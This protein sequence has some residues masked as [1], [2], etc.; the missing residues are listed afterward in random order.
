MR[1]TWSGMISF[2]L[3]NIPVKVYTAAREEKISFHQMH[4][5]DS[6]RVRYDKVCKACGSSLSTEDIVKGYEYRKGQYVIITDEDLDKIDLPTTR[7]I[8]VLN[9]VDAAEIDA[10]QFDKG[11]YI[12]PDENGERA[13]SLLRQALTTTGKIG[14]GKVAFRNHEQ[15]AAIRVADNALVLET[16]HFCDEMVGSGGMGCRHAGG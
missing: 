13:Y 12:A 7:S 1:A 4:K 15:L 3:V 5:E 11:F 6:G 8:S 16:L 14:I 9:F 10:L 2:G